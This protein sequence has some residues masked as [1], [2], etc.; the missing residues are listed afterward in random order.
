MRAKVTDEGVVIPR[1]ML[2]GVEE[3]EIRSGDGMVLVFPVRAEDPIL[4][5][6]NAPVRC[7]V[8]DGSV[9]HDRDPY[10]TAD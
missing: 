7:G 1:R 3:V 8:P 2:P 10:G 5:L 6:G 4:G 9:H